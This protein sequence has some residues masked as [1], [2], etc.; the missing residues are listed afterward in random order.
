MAVAAFWTALEP[1]GSDPLDTSHALPTLVLGLVALP[2][3]LPLVALG[4]GGAVGSGTFLVL[5]VLLAW[6]EA[7]AVRWACTRL[8]ARRRPGA[9]AAPAAQNAQNA[10]NG[11]GPGGGR[12]DGRTGRGTRSGRQ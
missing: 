6:A 12:P 7:A 1:W 3:V 4:V 2:A 9:P 5:V 11:K 10:P 8:L